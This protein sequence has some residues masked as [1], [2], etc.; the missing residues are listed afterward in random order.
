MS[1]SFMRRWALASLLL[2]WPSRAM[3]QELSPV[4]TG[5]P[6]APDA[7]GEFDPNAQAGDDDPN[8]SPPAAPLVV[9]TALEA[10][11]QKALD[12]AN[13]LLDA[14]D[15]AAVD[16]ARET[17]ASA[18]KDLNISLGS[19][20]LARTSLP[21]DPFSLRLA[22]GAIQAH[23][24]WGRA[25]EEFGRRDEA[26][27]ALVRAKT[28]LVALPAPPIGTFSRDLNLQLN[29]LLRTGLPL[30]APE[31][32]LS[33]IAA[34]VQGNLWKTRRFEF[35]PL[36]GQNRSS[37]LLVTQGQ[38]F[39][40]AGRDGNL[41]KIPPMYREIA[42]DRL[43]SSLQLNRMVAG[44]ER[45]GNTGNWRQ[46]VR[47]F[48][49]SP[50][51][52][53]NKRD[54]SPRAAALATQ[55]LRVHATYASQLGATNLY[56][57]DPL[58]EGVTTLYLLEISAIWPQD[59]DDPVVLANL[60]PKMPPINIG[61]RPNASL[62]RTTPTMRPWMPIAGTNEAQPG[63]ILFWKAGASRSEAEWLRELFHEYGHVALPPLGGF[64]P[65]LEPYA[66]G[67][68]GETLG[69]LWAGQNAGFS[70]A[71]GKIISANDFLFQVQHQA[72][73]AR[74]T[75]LRADPRAPLAGGTFADLRFLQGLCVVC[76]RVYGA[77]ILG[78]A[79][80]PLSERAANTSNVAARRSLLGAGDLLDALEPA[81]RQ[82]FA[83]RRNLPIY[84][85]A[86]LDLPLDAPTLI[87][88]APVSLRAGTQTRGWIYVPTGAQSLRI[89]ASGLSALGFPWNREGSATKIYFG[90]KSGWQRLSLVARADTVLSGARFE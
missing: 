89:E 90:G 58:D 60:G 75:F 3:A 6:M 19:D 50:F 10:A 44:Y 81:M 49:A 53:K 43:P 85:P 26:I 46:V 83:A 15:P 32:V 42:A 14:R 78:R 40:P 5:G 76:E 39:P 67:L 4:P 47:V 82:G 72:I 23:A 65:P 73:P 17:S 84:L 63:E 28:L 54:D 45:A 70:G 16:L 33:G 13:A 66:N 22:M 74:E 48:Y 35:S 68:I 24:L 52:T 1:Y 62:P 79:F 27:T 88:R 64:R 34:H 57:R 69:A 11:T 25:A 77:P 8:F 12:R 29:T 80:A 37:A 31:D 18:L 61:P 59:D 30:S 41:V 56:A 86:A 71:D 21:A 55:F 36:P 51:L 2:V 9:P 87:G 20:A 38:L 7:G